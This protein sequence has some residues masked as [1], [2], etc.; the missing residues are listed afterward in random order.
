MV[1]QSVRHLV[2]ATS[3]V[4][5]ILSPATRTERPAKASRRLTTLQS[6]DLGLFVVANPEDCFVAFGSSQRHYK[7]N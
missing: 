2:G 1:E 3:W 6:A 7:G 4:K 5:R